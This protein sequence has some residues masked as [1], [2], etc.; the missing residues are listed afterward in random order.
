MRFLSKGVYSIWKGLSDRV[1]GL[2]PD[3][4]GV[5]LDT[6]RCHD[7]GMNPS[8]WTNGVAH[9]NVGY[10]D[11]KEHL[12]KAMFLLDDSENLL[13][14]V[15]GEELVLQDDLIAVCPQTDCRCATHMVCLSSRFL[16]GEG[17]SNQLVPTSGTC[18]ACKSTVTWSSLM[19]ELSVRLRGEKETQDIF[20]TK[21]KRRL[22]AGNTS[23]DPADSPGDQQKHP[24]R[25]VSATDSVNS[26]QADEDHVMSPEDNIYN[27]YDD[28]E[29]HLDENWIETVDLGSDSDLA[30]HSEAEAERKQSR[31]EIVIED[32]DWDD[33]EIVE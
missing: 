24:D 19:K 10:H 3:T 17:S 14:G 6:T 30:D 28:D 32:S 11:M 25:S 26:A 23:A 13:C 18:P 21:R 15:C 20:K 5:N 33:A 22:K 7:I 31:V 8:P 16:N 9:V 12:E 4:I 1:D 27:G 29:L 2:L